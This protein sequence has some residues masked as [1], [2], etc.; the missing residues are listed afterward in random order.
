MRLGP[1]SR[2][3]NLLVRLVSLYSETPSPRETGVA[4]SE[5][6]SP[7]ETGVAVSETPSPAEKSTVAAINSELPVDKPS[8]NV[9]SASQTSLVS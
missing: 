2:K 6:P 5:T 8:A 4:V 1:L 3:P 9:S 7:R